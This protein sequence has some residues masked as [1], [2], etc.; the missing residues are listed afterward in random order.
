MELLVSNNL[1][2]DQAK[3]SD[4]F[5][6]MPRSRLAR[7]QKEIYQQLDALSL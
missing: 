3:T 6:L 2:F 5:T 1:T 7:V 4:I